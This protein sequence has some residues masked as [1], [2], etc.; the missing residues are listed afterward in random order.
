MPTP[1]LTLSRAI[2]QRELNRFYAHPVAKVSLGLILS[3]ITIGFFA[4][5]AIKPTLETMSNLLK[6]IEE[7]RD[8]DQRLAQKISALATAQRELNQ[9]G[10]AA[11]VLDRSVPT[12]PQFT[13]L[14]KKLEK[15]A[16]EN[17]LTFVSLVSSAAP[18]ERTPHSGIELES[19]PLILSFS[20]EYNNIRTFILALTNIDRLISI[21]DVDIVP[22]SEKEAKNLTV[23]FNVRAFAFTAEPQIK[24]K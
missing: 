21:D 2:L 9:K 4:L 5:V 18:P 6:E 20:G 8:V 17:N 1:R 23:S 16:A 14:L 24:K 3:I 15:L 19:I 13:F 12:T 10:E 22:P 11:K 7:K